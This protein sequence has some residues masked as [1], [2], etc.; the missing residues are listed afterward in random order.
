MAPAGKFA[1][2]WDRLPLHLIEGPPTS[3][4]GTAQPRQAV[5]LVIADGPVA[6]SGGLFGAVTPDTQLVST[7]LTVPS[8]ELQRGRRNK[9]ALLM[10]LQAWPAQPRDA[11]IPVSHCRE[12]TGFLGGRGVRRW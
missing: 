11:A 12:K 4:E 5:P 10:D 3:L 9:G 7:A 6:T 2:A 1:G 8:A